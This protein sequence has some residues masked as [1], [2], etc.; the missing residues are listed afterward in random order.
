MRIQD[1]IVKAIAGRL[2]W[3]QINP[4]PSSKQKMGLFKVDQHS[5]SISVSPRADVGREVSSNPT[6]GM[7]PHQTW[8]GPGITRPQAGT[9][10]PC[11]FGPE[12]SHASRDI[13]LFR[14]LFPL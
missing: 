5:L 2:K 14:P 1:V 8:S 4:L 3:Y 11:A 7:W 10:T 9:D 12:S 13:T 6:Y